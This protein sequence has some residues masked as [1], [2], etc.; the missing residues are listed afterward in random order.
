MIEE[1][2]PPA[3]DDPARGSETKDRAPR[4]PA[5]ADELIDA[6]ADTPPPPAPSPQQRR[7][8][9]LLLGANLVL[10]AFNLR[11]AVASVGP[12]L[13][14]I[15][16]SAGLSPAGASALTTLPSLC[17]GLFAPLAPWLSRRYGTERTVMAVLGAMVLGT[18]LRGL[19][20]A[21]ALFGGQILACAGIAVINVLLPGLVKR[22]FPHR[23]ALMTALYVTSLGVGAA[24]AAGSTVP[25]E[26][27]FGSWAAA[28]AV[29]AAPAA[30]A[31]AIWAVQIARGARA[32]ARRGVVVRG[33]WSDPLA[34]QVTLFMGLQSAF[35]YIVFGW[36]APL[37]RDR[38]L[39]PVEAGLVVSVSILA[40]AAGSMFAP[41]IAMFGR[42][43]RLASGISTLVCVG[44]FLG[45]VFGPLAFIWIWSIIL[46]VS[47]GAL[48]AIA[49]LLIVLRSPDAHVAAHLS[50]MSQ[51]V[52][53]VLASAGPLLAGLLHGWS[54][55]WNALA[56]LL[57]ALGAAMLAS[58][59]G[60]SRARHV[61][62]V[63]VP[64]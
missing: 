14:E 28:L 56:W 25:L 40:Q 61:G 41:S 17:F 18:A 45:C 55:S 1:G 33:L 51:S 19:A 24:I 23:A 39:D 16:R 49:L 34:W 62:A 35:A 64:V 30:L 57:L 36:L 7:G 46:G 50:T 3:P 42:D 52:G 20:G 15:A 8:Q 37:L 27:R 31:A 59:V 13:P 26:R 43:Q 32:P 4:Y 60:A 58:G 29:W 54:G 63:S 48:F 12:V 9:V 44:S 5:L 21:P 2:E 38:G 6:E 10:I 53:Y 47:E 11:C 22:D